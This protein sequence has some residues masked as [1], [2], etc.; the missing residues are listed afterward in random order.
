M[1]VYLGD[2]VLRTDEGIEVLPLE[3][4]LEELARGLPTTTI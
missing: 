2:C 1:I 4:L 3:R